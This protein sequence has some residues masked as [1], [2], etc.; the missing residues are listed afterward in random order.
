MLHDRYFVVRH[1][2]YVL[3]IG[4]AFGILCGVTIYYPLFTGFVINK[5]ITIGSFTL[6]FI[7]VNIT[8]FPLHFV[9]LH[10]QPRKYT[11]YNEVY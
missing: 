5:P 3:S 1:F 11:E 6:I 2:H 9:G 7:G 10:G 4:A 8:F